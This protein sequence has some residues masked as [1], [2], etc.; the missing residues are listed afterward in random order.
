MKVKQKEKPYT[1]NIKIN[2]QY[3]TYQYEF[4]HDKEISI[5]EIAELIAGKL[6]CE[7]QEGKFLDEK[8]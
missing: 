4:E 8:R 1:F 3:C 2:D 5:Y 6:D 7:L